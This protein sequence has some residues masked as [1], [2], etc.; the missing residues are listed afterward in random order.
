MNNLPSLK[1]DF[2]GDRIE[3]HVIRR[4]I[5]TLEEHGEDVKALVLDLRLQEPRTQ[6]D[7][8]FM[9]CSWWLRPGT[10]PLAELSRVLKVADA[11]YGA[12]L[13]G[14]WLAVELGGT[15]PAYGPNKAP[16]KLYTVEYRARDLAEE[17]QIVEELF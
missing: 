13:P 4:R 1:F 11:L 3:S 12:P 5:V 15:R 14:D 8:A 2:V 9:E 16:K 7:R 10:Q 17:Q 6:D